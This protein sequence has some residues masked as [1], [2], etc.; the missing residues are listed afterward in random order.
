MSARER[1]PG[2]FRLRR[3]AAGP[4][5]RRHA[6]RR[7]VTR[8]RGAEPAGGSEAGRSGAEAGEGRG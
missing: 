6:G 1:R 3:R 5:L 2:H 4:S 7:D 8:R